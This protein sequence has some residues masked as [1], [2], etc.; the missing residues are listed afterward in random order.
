[1]DSSSTVE[2]ACWEEAVDVSDPICRTSAG[3][4][5]ADVSGCDE[6]LQREIDQ[7]QREDNPAGELEECDTD[8]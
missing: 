7:R 2:E 8:L 3:A 4:G 1:M 6:D 5:E